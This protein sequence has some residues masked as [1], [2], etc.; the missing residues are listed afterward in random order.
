MSRQLRKRDAC[1][2]TSA[3]RTLRPAA[4]IPLLGEYSSVTALVLHGVR[5]TH[6][7]P[8]LMQRLAPCGEERF[9]TQIAAFCGL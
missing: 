4:P 9:S 1:G 2:K 6:L 5:F 7:R 3:V 8:L